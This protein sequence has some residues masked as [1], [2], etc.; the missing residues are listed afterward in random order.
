MPRH[1][2][3]T[4]P[5]IRLA[6]NT[7]TPLHRQLVEG[8]RSAILRGELVPGERLPSTRSLASDLG[9]SRSTVVA[10]FEQLNVEGYL[11]SRVGSGTRVPRDLPIEGL[12]DG[13]ARPTGNIPTPGGARVRVD[14]PRPFRPGVPDLDRLAAGP[15]GRALRRVWRE[16]AAD[17]IG[18]ST[19]A[20]DSELRTEIAR[21]L[22]GVRRV[23]CRPEQVLV[24]SGTQEGLSL[25]CELVAEAGDRIWIENPGYLGAQRAIRAVG[26]EPVAV[27]LDR[28]GLCI[29]H[30]RSRLP[31]AVACY[32]TPSHQFPMGTTLSASR[33]AELLEWASE[34]DGWI[35]E[36]DYDSEFRLDGQPLPA[37]QGLDRNERVLY[38]GS[39]SKALAPGLRLGYVIVPD[40]L[41][42]EALRRKQAR[43]GPGPTWLHRVVAQFM[44]EGLFARHIR[45]IR[46]LY[47]ARL[48]SLRASV[49]RHLPDG[50][51]IRD[52]AGCMHAIL[53]LPE[54]FPTDAVARAA[55]E[56]DV[57]V[58]P[59]ER[60]CLPGT[61]PP[62]HGLV[63]G[64]AAWPEEELDRA[65]RI[66]GTAL[67]EESA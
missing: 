9:V 67:D 14:M 63:L 3:G 65:V 57:D 60:F 40:S 38:V 61:R 66:L 34:T 24:T 56:R 25:A 15:F 18:G 59:L 42:A 47:R 29:G 52:P 43:W 46:T 64:F 17:L 58:I 37:L 27:P 33:R 20:G 8:L 16:D 62:G 49:A 10:A 7:R 23:R 53:H 28:E 39:F 30:A 12:S 36:D 4:I 35:I 45:A 2:R 21:H 11:E 26:A 13:S 19:V 6:R 5:L 31:S 50:C 55:S 54:E 51:R 44:A 48:E 32:I 41:L 1:P 22:R